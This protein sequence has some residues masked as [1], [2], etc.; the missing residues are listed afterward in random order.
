M[1]KT[2]F[3]ALALVSFILL[4]SAP[5]GSVKC[6]QL[7]GNTQLADALMDGIVA[8]SMNGNAHNRS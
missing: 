3:T 4:I 5:L 7:D 6:Q 8:N 1:L 2:G